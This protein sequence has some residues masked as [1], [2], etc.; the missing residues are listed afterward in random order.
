MSN[1]NIFAYDL[2]LRILAG[3]GTH[4]V[5]VVY[6]QG[7]TSAEQTLLNTAGIGSMAFGLIGTT[8]G[9][10][11]KVSNAGTP[12]SD[13]RKL[14]NLD[15]VQTAIATVNSSLADSNWR[16]P[17][18]ILT[19]ESV[20]QIETAL[21][22]NNG[23]G[24]YR[25]ATLVSGNLVLRQ[26]VSNVYVAT[27]T[28]NNWT[29]TA[30][31]V[32]RSSI[33]GD[34]FPI[35]RSDNA[36]PAESFLQQRLAVFV[37]GAYV[38]SLNYGDLDPLSQAISAVETTVNWLESNVEYAHLK[39]SNLLINHVE[40]TLFSVNASQ[41]SGIEFTYTA[42]SDGL[43]DGSE[44]VIYGSRT[45]KVMMVIPHHDSAHSPVFSRGLMLETG[46]DIK[47]PVFTAVVSGTGTSKIVTVKAQLPDYSSQYVNGYVSAMIPRGTVDLTPTHG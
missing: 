27:K 18:S 44:N 42:D 26:G 14:A 1:E 30:S 2:G 43:R 19:S 12:I 33:N 47:D 36:S 45:G 29:V 6:S 39:F 37:D 46:V 28:G 22:L 38:V 16:K 25:G 15:D 11:E 21:N 7:Y 40:Q 35:L 31:G 41:V 32:E 9:I 20:A 5:D 23:A 34:V 24:V 3:D 4:H 17:I 13:W 8:S 10:F